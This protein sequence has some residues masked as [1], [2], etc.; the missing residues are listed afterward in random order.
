MSRILETSFHCARFSVALRPS[1]SFASGAFCAHECTIMFRLLLW[2]SRSAI[3]QAITDKKV[4]K[5]T[6]DP[7][8][9]IS[10]LPE[11]LVCLCVR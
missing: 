1:L 10:F 5:Q 9:T 2:T 6:F 3:Q 11:V 8:S 4:C 7:G